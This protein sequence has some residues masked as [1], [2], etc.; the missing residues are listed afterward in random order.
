M[1]LF[2]RRWRMGSGQ[3]GPEMHELGIVD[4]PGERDEHSRTCRSAISMSKGSAWAP[5]SN[6]PRRRPGRPADERPVGCRSVGAGLER[7]RTRRSP[8][9]RERCSWLVSDQGSLRARVTS[10]ADDPPA[11]VGTPPRRTPSPAPQQV[12]GPGSNPRGRRHLHQHRHGTKRR[13]RTATPIDV[14]LVPHPATRHRSDRRVP[15][16]ASPPA[17]RD[18][19]PPPGWRST[20]RARVSIRYSRGPVI[21]LVPSRPWRGSETVVWELSATRRVWFVALM[22]PM[23]CSGRRVPFAGGGCCR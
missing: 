21:D 8:R 6:S 2:G 22:A 13:I 5:G 19:D 23:V 18:H 10:D 17:R 11:T 4:G 3:P 16:T 20:G 15:P 7:R 12:P 1:A 14:A 9:R